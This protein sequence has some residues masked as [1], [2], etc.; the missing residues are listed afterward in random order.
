MLSK[1][2]ND[3]LTQTGP[4][5]PCGKFLRSYWQPVATSQEMPIGGDPL[6]IRIMSEDLVLFRDDKDHLGLIG[7]ACP[8]R[9][10]DL[11]YG[12]VEDGGLRCLYHGWLFDRHGNCLDQPAEPQDK[13]FCHKVRH[14]AYPVQEK[15][16][17]I[18]AYMGEGEPPLIPDFEFLT[19]PEPNRITFR[20]LQTCNW[21]Q[22]LE[23]STDPAHTTYLHRRPPGI[24][25]VRSGN[26]IAALRG[27][28][29]PSISI[30]QTSFGTRIFALH[31]SPAGKKYLRV[32]N[33]V[34]PNGATPSTSTGESGYQGR[35]YVPVDDYN[36]Y[37][38]EFFYRHSEPLNKERLIQNHHENVAEDH[39]H[40]RR[41]ENRYLQDR[42]QMK[43]GASF[44]GMGIYF[45]AQDAFAIE[46]QGAIQDRT[47]E[48]LG[49]TDI[50]IIAVRQA[51]LKAIQKV[52][53]GEE[54]PWL[55]REP[56]KNAFADF[57]CTSGYIEDHEDGPSFCRRLLSGKSDKP[58]AA[59]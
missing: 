20:V 25:S 54:A 13:K 10:T 41:P 21:L 11:S 6:P 39:R 15:G 48:Y 28:D 19:G 50:V 23:S 33:Y 31:N 38:Y 43:S 29:P 26:D 53:D 46:T 5:T 8:H 40:V 27:N 34:Y 58:T 16:G 47:Q 51:L 22:G 9:A 56:N 12:R 36:H 3:L 49:S 42:E 4:G 44:G 45:P 1:A 55:Q 30:E 32:N 18:W 57:I 7:R 14:K 52:E 24:A 2:K 17:A 37:R 35:W 59:E